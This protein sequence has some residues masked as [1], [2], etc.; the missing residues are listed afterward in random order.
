MHHRNGCTSGICISY[1]LHIRWTGFTKTLT[2]M[3]PA[4]HF[5]LFERGRTNM[6]FNTKRLEIE[7]HRDSL[8][9]RAS[10]FG[11]TFQTFRDFSGAGLSATDWIKAA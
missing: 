2:Q 11:R 6:H 10:F 1:R 9:L 5:G 8:W 4:N 7:L 3:P